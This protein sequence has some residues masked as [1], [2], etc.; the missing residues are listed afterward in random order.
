MLPAFRH[1]GLA[2]TL[3]HDLKYRGLRPVA[4][5]MASEMAGDIP[6]A[7]STLVPIPR[8]TLRRLSLGVDPALELAYALSRLTGLP[9]VPSLRAPA[10]GRRH[11]GRSQTDRHPVGF[12]L[13]GAVPA[14]S[15]LID[16]VVTTGATL[17][18]AAAAAG[19]SVIG[20]VT[21][22]GASV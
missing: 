2:R 1:D 22:T 13:R 6:A 21:A 18:S 5:L 10:W 4:H 9:T 19:P 7:A 12:A 20:A 17:V 11:A 14:G 3:I 8:V 15:V 16:D